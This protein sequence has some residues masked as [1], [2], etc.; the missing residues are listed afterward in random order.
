MISWWNNQMQLF[1]SLIIGL[2]EL[3]YHR[4]AGWCSLEDYPFFVQQHFLHHSLCSVRKA[5]SQSNIKSPYLWNIRVFPLKSSVKCLCQYSFLFV[6]QISLFT[7]CRQQ[8]WLED[9]VRGGVAID[10]EHLARSAALIV[11]ISSWPF[12]LETIFYKFVCMCGTYF[13]YMIL[14]LSQFLFCCPQT[15]SLIN[16][17]VT[18]WLSH[19]IGG[20]SA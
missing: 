1:E 4:Q 2:P 13:K 10:V 5:F 7:L 15:T 11:P 19:C 12:Y 9:T 14:V 8:Q 17:M 16:D 20:Y 3:T 6:V 18:C